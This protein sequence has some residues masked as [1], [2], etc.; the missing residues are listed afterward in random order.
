MVSLRAMPE[1][2]GRKAPQRWP[3]EHGAQG[4]C[5]R[6]QAVRDP[7]IALPVSRVPGPPLSY[8]AAGVDI[9]A[10]NEAVRRIKALVARTRRPEQL[11]EIGGF[12]G[13]MA[14]PNVRD[15]VLVSCTD[16][17]GTKLLV[18]IA[19]NRHDTVG[20]DL[21]AM[22]VNDLLCTG[23]EPL[24]VLDY[25]AT[26]KI[27]PHVVE[28]IVAGIVDGCVQAGCALLGGETAEMPGMYADGHYDLAAF[29]VGVVGRDAR[30]SPALP[31]E[32]DVVL[33]LPSSGLHS[34]G[35]S[36]ARKALLDPDYGALALHDPLPTDPGTTVG[37]ALLQPTKIYA[38]A[39]K[40]ALREGGVH[41]AAHI[42]GGGLIENPPR[43]LP[44]HLAM[45]LWLGEVPVPPIQRAIADVGVSQLELRRTFNGG[46]GMLLVVDPERAT[47]IAAAVER[48]GEPALTVGRV[49]ASDG[50]ERVRFG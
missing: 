24:F 50:G 44:E 19:M 47:A 11:D 30:L 5:A 36:L 40:A 32:G 1:G 26:G 15:P 3:D 4:L 31:R 7:G 48:T 46:L 25:V 38:R 8:R 12:A 21:V 18:A 9:D 27:D 43:C 16:G 20:I 33:G 17:V 23:A 10:G 14:L 35:Y 37:D 28:Q 6:R 13:M 29:A 22:N 42:T 2:G 45:E 39:M 49:V 41:G 34:N